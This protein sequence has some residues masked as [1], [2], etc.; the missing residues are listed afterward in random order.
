MTSGLHR[1]KC[2]VSSVSLTKCIKRQLFFAMNISRLFS[3]YHFAHN[4]D[5]TRQMF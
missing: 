4:G 2:I 3:S 5:N 1:T